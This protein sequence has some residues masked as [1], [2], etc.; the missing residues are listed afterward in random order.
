MK[1][2]LRKHENGSSLFVVLSVC[3]IVG[4]IL[5]GYLVLT[6]NRFQM[7]AR[8]ADWNA[9][10]PVLEAGVEESLTHITRDTNDLSKNNWISATIGGAQAYTKTRTFSDGSYFYAYIRDF[11]ANGATIYSSGF[12]RSPYKTDQYI[13][14]TVK[15]GVTNPPSVFT[16]ALAVN[17]TVSLAGGPIVDGFDSRK[18]PYSTSTNRDAAG[19][20]VTNSKLVGAVSLSGAHVYGEVITGPGGTVSGGTVGDVAWNTSSSGIETGWTNNTMN[21]AYPSNSPPSGG[22]YL[23]PTQYTNMTSGTYQ[24]TGTYTSSGNITITGNV[25]LYVTGDF[26]LKGSDTI[27]IKPGASLK[28]IAGG[29]VGIGGGGVYNNTGFAVN[30]SVIGLTSCASVNFTGNAQFFGTVNAPQADFILKGTADAFGAIIANSA[31]MNG[32][33]ALHYD[34][35]LAYSYAYIVN[36]WQEL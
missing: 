16:H 27:T 25:T 9:A 19:G 28:L 24:I 17:G 32:N 33:T 7:T 12:V 6:S 31:T 36:S 10:I 4:I 1:L 20:I 23:P 11:T 13:A 3:M 34:E 18:G 22:P 15:V 8:S 14:R 5:A 35:S 30:F 2:R 21:V 26:N 29:N